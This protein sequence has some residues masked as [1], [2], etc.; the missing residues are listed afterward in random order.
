MIESAHSSNRAG[1]VYYIT[2]GI[3]DGLSNN[4]SGLDE[5]LRTQAVNM[6]AMEGHIIGMAVHTIKLA[7]HPMTGVAS[8]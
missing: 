3:N 7:V 8:G 5:Y 2:S 1:S 4:M 6:V